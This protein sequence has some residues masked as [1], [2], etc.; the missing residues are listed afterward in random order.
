MRQ[1][2]PINEERIIKI[3]NTKY[4]R[5]TTQ[6]NKK[7]SL[8]HTEANRYLYASETKYGIRSTDYFEPP[9]YL[10]DLEQAHQHIKS[11][12]FVPKEEKDN[13]L[14]IEQLLK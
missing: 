5:L 13:Y 9:S 6:I 3:I 7:A 14:L 10:F 1:D 2:Y 11:L 8:I 4:F 12:K